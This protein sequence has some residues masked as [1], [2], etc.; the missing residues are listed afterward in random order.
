[1]V[2]I[3]GCETLWTPANIIEDQIARVRAAAGRPVEH[4]P[5]EIVM[6]A[7]DMVD[8]ALAGLDQGEVVTI[9][10]LPD[11]AEWDSYEAARRAMSANLSHSA[12]AA[13][14]AVAAPRRLNKQQP[15][16]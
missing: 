15:N 4:L 10:A 12:P 5:S 6:T 2:D 1:M 9:P 14:Y 7:A 13:R 8:A 11:K 16:L 3:C